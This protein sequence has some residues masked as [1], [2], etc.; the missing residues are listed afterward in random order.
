[1]VVLVRPVVSLDRKPARRTY[2]INRHR[3]AAKTPLD[4]LTHLLSP[5]VNRDTISSG[6][7]AEW[8]R[9]MLCQR[10]IYIMDSFSIDTKFGFESELIDLGA[11]SMTALRELDDMVLRQALRH[12]MQQTAYPRVTAGGGSQG[13]LVVD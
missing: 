1:L 3:M 6:A 12:V 9:S 8:L 13:E 10:G 5:P 11:V 2:L 7:S 4:V